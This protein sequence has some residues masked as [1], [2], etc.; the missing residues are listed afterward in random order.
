M[1]FVEYGFEEQ[2]GTV[3]T[4]AGAGISIEKGAE[5][6]LIDSLV[7]ETSAVLGFEAGVE[8]ASRGSILEPGRGCKARGAEGGEG[9]DG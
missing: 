2:V 6:E 4:R 8:V 5:V 7:D 1:Q 9:G 3:R